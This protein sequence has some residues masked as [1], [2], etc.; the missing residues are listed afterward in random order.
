M[1]E[2]DKTKFRYICATVAPFN[3]ASLKDKFAHGLEIVSLKV[4]YGNMLRYIL[5][6]DLSR[7]SSE[8]S[9]LESRYIPMANTEEQQ[10]LLENGW[11]GTYYRKKKR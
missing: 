3:I 8:S 10:Q 7:V 11:I 6:K 2:V 5:L 4:K 9:T 1:A